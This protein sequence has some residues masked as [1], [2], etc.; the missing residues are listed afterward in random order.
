MKCQ[1]RRIW[2]QW[3]HYC[4]KDPSVDSKCDELLNNW[5]FQELNAE[6]FSRISTTYYFIGVGVS[7]NLWTTRLQFSLS[8]KK[9]KDVG[10]GG[11]SLESWKAWLA[12]NFFKT[13]LRSSF[14]S[15]LCTLMQN[16][17]NSIAKEMLF[18]YG[19]KTAN[20]YMLGSSLM[21]VSPT[22]RKLYS[23]HT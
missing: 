2:L 11:S 19:N 7:A 15:A 1:K 23:T 17:N 21:E 8:R 18:V 16:S 20:S 13:K 10:V 9:R 22:G 5:L 12:I 3:P 14:E 6:W 4:Y